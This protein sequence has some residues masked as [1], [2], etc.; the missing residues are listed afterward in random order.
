MRI[1]HVI[2]RQTACERD[3]RGAF[4]VRKRKRWAGADRS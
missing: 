1:D 2:I 3:G 4:V